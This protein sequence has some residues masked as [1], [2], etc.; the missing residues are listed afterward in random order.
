[1]LYKH[2]VLVNP[3]NLLIDPK[4]LGWKWKKKILIVKCL[5][6]WHEKLIYLSEMSALNTEKLI[7]S[8]H[9]KA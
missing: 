8:C 3:E 5:H 4:I 7:L 6:C 2:T 1:M 9:F